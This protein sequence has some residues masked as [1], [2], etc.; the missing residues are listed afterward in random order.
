MTGILRFDG[1]GQVR[2]AGELESSWGAAEDRVGAIL[3]SAAFEFADLRS[4]RPEEY[5][6]QYDLLEEGDDPD[7]VDVTIL[8][9]DFE[10]VI[11]LV[12]YEY[13]VRLDAE[14]REILECYLNEYHAYPTRDFNQPS[15]PLREVAEVADQEMTLTQ[16]E[17]G[18]H[19]D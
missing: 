9:E 11:S 6:G 2:A 7:A 8:P 10:E 16:Y 18:G 1:V 5:G 15:L 19:D 17:Q 4:A 12:E 14:D 3:A 13:G